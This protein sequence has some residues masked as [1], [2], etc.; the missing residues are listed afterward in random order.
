MHKF[1]IFVF[2]LLNVVGA[3]AQKG[4]DKKIMDSLK[5]YDPLISMLDSLGKPHSYCMLDLGFGNRS[6][7]INNRSL[8]ALQTENRLVITPSLSYYHKSGF[9]ISFAGNLFSDSGVTKFYQ[10][11][12]T[13]SYEYNSDDVNADVSYSR[14][15]AKEDFTANTP[16]KNDFYGSVIIKKPWLEPGLGIGYSTGEY[17]EIAM[18]TAAIPGIGQ[19][20]FPDTATTKLKAFTL[21]GMVEHSFDWYDL[22]GK[23]DNLNVTPT[24][25]LNCGSSTY[26]IKHRNRYSTSVANRRTQLRKPSNQVTRFQLESAGMNLALIYATGIFYFQP[27]LYLDYYI[28]ASDTKKFTQIVSLNIGI[29]F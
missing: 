17:S 16:I 2:C 7:S 25:M 12:L 1:F 9:G 11:S 18:V 6:F 13:P 24:L 28:P 29:T 10:W 4:E 20:T 27:Q 19:R 8:N 21:I 15:F 14:Y 22:I 3:I 5:K 23:N 26:D